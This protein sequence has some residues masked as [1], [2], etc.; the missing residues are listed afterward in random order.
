[1]ETTISYSRSPKSQKKW[2]DWEL[3]LLELAKAKKLTAADL[4]PVLRRKAT[5]IRS[6]SS[7]IGFGIPLGE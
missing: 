4:A 3:R 1:M 7:K 2:L 6:K 5:A